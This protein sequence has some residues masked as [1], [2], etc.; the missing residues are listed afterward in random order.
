MLLTVGVGAQ[1]HFDR[2]TAEHPLLRLRHFESRWPAQ[3]EGVLHSIPT[4]IFFGLYLGHQYS[5]QFPYS[6]CYKIILLQTC[7]LLFSI[8][9][10]TP[11][12]L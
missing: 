9:T 4:I 3:R 12:A 8:Y 7:I 1:V 11:V 10:C 6:Q 5:T 2:P